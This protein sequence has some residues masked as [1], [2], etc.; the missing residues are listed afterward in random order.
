MADIKTAIIQGAPHQVG[1]E[2]FDRFCLPALKATE[3]RPPDEVMQC[4][5]GFLGSLLGAMTADFGHG[6]AT[7]IAR[8][9]VEQFAGMADAFKAEH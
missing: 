1:A 6:T 7:A 3:G 8:H 5:A 2:V 9:T 4:Y